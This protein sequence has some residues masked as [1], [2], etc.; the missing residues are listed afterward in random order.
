MQT[1]G[2]ADRKEDMQAG[3]QIC[4]KEDMQSSRQADMQ[5]GGFADKKEDMQIGRYAD[6][7]AGDHA[8]HAVSD[9]H[10]KNA[11]HSWAE[12][13]FDMTGSWRVDKATSETLD[14]LLKEM[15]VPW[16]ARKVVDGLEV[17]TVLRQAGSSDLFMEE[18]SR[19]GDHAFF[20]D[21]P[22]F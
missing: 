16:I 22:H 19:L 20:S 11:Q 18:K 4:R 2:Y 7:H 5:T 1:G 21:S 14:E 17:T 13:S 9:D 6:K 15:G 10:G 12:V 8:A 3:R